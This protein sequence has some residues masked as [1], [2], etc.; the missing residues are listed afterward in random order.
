ML[1]RSREHGVLVD[2]RF[3]EGVIPL[4]G[5]ADAPG[6]APVVSPPASARK[7]WEPQSEER[8]PATW[9]G[10]AVRRWFGREE[11]DR[12]RRDIAAARTPIADPPHKVAVTTAKGGEG[13]TTTTLHVASQLGLLRNDR[14]LAVECNQHHGTFRHR[15][16]VV[17]TRGVKELLRQLDTLEREED[18]TYDMLARHVT[19]HH[20][21]RLEILA[22]PMDP[23]DLVALQGADYR[24]VLRVLYR[25]FG[26]LL[27]DTGTGLRDEWTS[28]I[29]GEIADQV[30]VV[31]Q[32][33]TDG[34]ALADHTLDY[35]TALRGAPWVKS[36]AVVVVNQVAAG[37]VLSSAE[38]L[39]YFG[40]RARRAMRVR[41][42]R[43]LAA[44]GRLDW[45]ALDPATRAD[46]LALAAEIGRGFAA[47]QGGV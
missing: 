43:Y 23:A 13:K 37:G 38:L 9:M 39:R 28:A 45:T 24:R 36:R 26:L 33:S 4:G 20:E 40:G 27:L 44:G 1:D 16:P 18:L 30:V 3:Q 46:W 34:A 10:S 8:P 32:A 25:F 31:A 14:I 5:A 6:A 19:Q 2:E 41:H 47:P 29:L 7:P 15:V 22:S 42:D 21:A 12:R 35:L 17:H 11:E